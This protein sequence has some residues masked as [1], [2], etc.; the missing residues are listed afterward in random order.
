MGYPHTKALIISIFSFFRG[1]KMAAP[2]PSASAGGVLLYCERPDCRIVAT[3]S[4]A[5]VEMC[6]R[7]DQSDTEWVLWRTYEANFEF[8]NMP[9]GL[10][11]D[12]TYELVYK[13]KKGNLRMEIKQEIT[14]AGNTFTVAGD[15]W[16]EE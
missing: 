8:E 7:N 9:E 12:G 14:V 10:P 16:A 13:S 11:A 2:G 15:A 1:T 3:G 5:R 4:S 6:R